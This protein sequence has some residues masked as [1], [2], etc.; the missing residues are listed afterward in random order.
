MHLETRFTTIVNQR[1]A[2]PRIISEIRFFS[3]LEPLVCPKR[4][5][6]ELERPKRLVG[7]FVDCHIQVLQNT[8]SFFH[9]FHKLLLAMFQQALL[10]IY[11][12]KIF[13]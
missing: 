8:L 3:P 12:I 9:D 7:A 13:L 1:Q 11:V 4:S 6:S 10:N 2:K 5:I